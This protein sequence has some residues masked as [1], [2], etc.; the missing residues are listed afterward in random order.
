M[1]LDSSL[2]QQQQQQDQQGNL[3]GLTSPLEDDAA[4]NQEAAAAAAGLRTN[5]AS[6]NAAS[7][8]RAGEEPRNPRRDLELARQRLQQQHQH[9]EEEEEVLQQ[10]QQEQQREQQQQ[11]EGDEEDDEFYGDGLEAEPWDLGERSGEETPVV[12]VGRCVSSDGWRDSSGSSSDDSWVAASPV[13]EPA[14]GG[15]GG[16]RVACTNWGGGPVE[17]QLEGAEA[18]AWIGEAVRY[19]ELVV[20]SSGSSTRLDADLGTADAAAA[21]AAAAVAAGEGGESASPKLTAA[22]R[23]SFDPAATSKVLL[24]GAE[25]RRP[26]SKTTAG[27]FAFSRAAEAAAVAAAAA[28]DN[29]EAMKHVFI[30]VLRL[31]KQLQQ[32]AAQ[33]D[34][35]G[36][37]C[38]NCHSSEEKDKQQQ[39]KQQQQQQQPQQQQQRLEGSASVPNISDDGEGGRGSLSTNC[40]CCAFGTPLSIGAALSQLYR[41]NP[42]RFSLLLHDSVLMALLPLQHHAAAALADALADPSPLVLLLDDE[43]CA[44]QLLDGAAEATAARVLA[45]AAA[46][47]GSNTVVEPEHKQQQQQQR[48]QQVIAG[49]GVV[50]GEGFAVA[51]RRFLLGNSSS[52][53]SRLMQQR[54]SWPGCLWWPRQGFDVGLSYSCCGVTLCQHKRSAAK[55]F[56]QRQQQALQQQ[57]QQQHLAQ[58]QLQQQ[59]H[60]GLQH[61]L[62]LTL[63]R[64]QQQ[65]Q[66]RLLACK[67]E[68]QQGTSAKDAEA[69]SRGAAKDASAMTTSRAGA[70]PAASGSVAAAR[71]PAECHW[72]RVCCSAV[73]ESS[74]HASPSAGRCA[75]CMRVE[76]QLRL[77]DGPPEPP[78]SLGMYATRLQHLA[79]VTDHELLMALLL[80][81]HARQRQRRFR[82]SD[83]NAHRLL[84]AALVLVSK[85]VRDDPTPLALWAV[86]GAVPP[87]E[88]AAMETALLE[89]LGHKVSFSLPEFAAVYCLA[90]AVSHMQRQQDQ[91]GARPQHKHKGPGSAE[92]AADVQGQQA[93]AD[94]SRGRRENPRSK[95][96]PCVSN[97]AESVSSSVKKDASEASEMQRHGNKLDLE[98]SALQR[99]CT[100][101]PSTSGEGRRPSLQENPVLK[102]LAQLQGVEE[103]LQ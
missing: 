2:S 72:G 32:L 52:S 63:Q 9:E 6:T 91:V 23:R 96:C 83:K 102:R 5:T 77:F 28:A 20:Q 76:E 55:R 50:S 46:A 43:G 79:S 68:P 69:V 84:L 14:G 62:Q 29:E 12:A 40:A 30:L 47:Y 11:Q 87:K 70:P 31:Y 71:A 58:R 34:V 94:G 60:L 3:L 19:M 100:Y 65:Q 37:G 54:R 18:D 89:L 101:P 66:Q 21:A 59:Q 39:D 26:R 56:L 97:A 44:S 75:A 10:Q 98:D 33:V 93:A 74:V 95:S 78:L 8:A 24:E 48:R 25:V 80:L 67:G 45:A 88:L 92:L 15:G 42:D 13:S 90:A 36:C 1:A 7:L 22:A 99:R 103:E 53:S 61:Q 86:V 49:A 51:A 4:A 41:E 64:Q 57:M 73:S 17:E 38:A 85:V 81:T 27:D 16:P 35:V 82:I